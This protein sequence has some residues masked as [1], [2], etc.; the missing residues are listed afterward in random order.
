VNTLINYVR[1]K[2]WISS[3]FAKETLLELSAGEKTDN[4]ML[5]VYTWFNFTIIHVDEF[6]EMDLEALKTWNI[7]G[8][9]DEHLTRP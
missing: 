1:G 5:I 6:T 2:T 9:L 4:C 8:D 7:S 3:T